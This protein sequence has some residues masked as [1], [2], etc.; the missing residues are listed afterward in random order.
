[1]GE[2]VWNMQEKGCMKM[3]EEH[4]NGHVQSLAHR[5]SNADIERQDRLALKTVE[6]LTTNYTAMSNYRAYSIE[7]A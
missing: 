1:M 5:V 4:C 3:H 6:I 2:Y 7:P